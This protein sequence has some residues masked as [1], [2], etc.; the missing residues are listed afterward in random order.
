[1]YRIAGEHTQEQPAV[2]LG[3]AHTQIGMA[4]RYSGVIIFQLCR[5][6]RKKSLRCEF[7]QD[8]SEIIR[9]EHHGARDVLV[10]EKLVFVRGGKL[11]VA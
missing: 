3:G 6:H 4:F 5:R 11:E 2:F 7:W 1:M 8:C 10:A 9:K